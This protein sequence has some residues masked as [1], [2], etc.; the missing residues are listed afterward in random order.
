MNLQLA[1]RIP[2]HGIVHPEVGHLYIPH[3]PGDDFAG[4]CPYHGDC[5][6]GMAAGTAIAERCGAP[7]NITPDHP[8]WARGAHY[9][10]SAT[11]NLIL[12]YSPERVILRGGIM[13][14]AHLFDQFEIG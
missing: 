4:N 12:A 11:T 8:A 10:G 5:L 6:E 13:Q 7:A 9:L 3:A 1:L 14:Q 2:V